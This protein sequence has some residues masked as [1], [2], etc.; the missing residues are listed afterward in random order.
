MKGVGVICQEVLSFSSDDFLFGLVQY[1]RIFLSTYIKEHANML[2][3]EGVLRSMLAYYRKRFCFTFQSEVCMGQQQG[4]H[5]YGFCPDTQVSLVYL[6]TP[7]LDTKFPFFNYSFILLIS[8][9]Q[10]Y[11]LTVDKIIVFIESSRCI[12]STSAIILWKIHQHSFQH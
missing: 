7:V 12:F 8:N 10:S 11:Y 1:P 2:I 3:Y 4:C 5:L 6:R 9:F